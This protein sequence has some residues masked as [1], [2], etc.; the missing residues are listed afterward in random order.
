MESITRLKRRLG[1]S[2]LLSGAAIA[3]ALYVIVYPFT[4]S[5]LPPITDLPFHAAA[6]S[7]FRHYWDETFRFHEQ[8]TLHPIEVPYISMYLL[9]AF[10]A[11][12]VPIV[13][14]VKAS[15]IVMLALLP[16]GLA[17]LCHGMKKTPLWGLLALA[18]V[19]TNLTWWGFLNHMGALGLYA[20]SVGFVLL[21]VDKPTR[22][23][24]WGLALALLAVFFTHVFRY[25]F[26]LL[27]VV[28][29]AVVV[30]PS[31]RRIL[32]IVLPILPSLAVFCAWWLV[33]PKELPAPGG[34]EGLGFFPKRL[35]ESWSHVTTSFG[36]LE[37]MREAALFDDA[38]SAIVVVALTALVWSLWIGRKRPHDSRRAWWSFGVTLLPLL[39]SGGFLLAYL[40]LPMRIGIWWYVYPRELTSALF[41]LLAAVPDMP[42]VWWL[43]LPLI[44]IVCI[45]VGRLGYFSALQFFQFERATADFLAVTRQIPKAPRLLY[46]VFD[47]G[48]S[49]RRVTPFIHLPAWVQAEKGGALSFQFVGWKQS[50]IQY[51]DVPEHVPPPVPDRWEWTPERY[52]HAEG[53]VWFDTFLIRMRRDPAYLFRGDPTIIPIAND[54]TWW[55]YRRER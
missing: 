25:P 11:L 18:L 34:P 38:K 46:L 3:L 15:A 33:R 37:G 40:T 47:H 53:G 16:I 7:I 19:W 44:A 27:S 28:A 8:F 54:G 52:R 21:V 9:G 35:D 42:R 43:R 23:R 24:R 1:A 36:G 4:V 39:L 12:F 30:Y 55:L 5:R 49:A 31:T 26:A 29:A 41:I 2:T 32:P 50:P 22:A 20:M 17:V 13:H 45:F 48:G 14:A 10:F 6:S 51:R